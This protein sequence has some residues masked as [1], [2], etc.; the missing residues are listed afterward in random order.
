MRFHLTTDPGLESLAAEEA[1]ELAPGAAI[2]PRPDGRRGRVR[3]DLP[4]RTGAGPLLAMRTIHHVI[5]LRAE[6]E[7]DSLDDVRRVASAVEIP[8]VAGATTF[9]VTT[10]RHGAH[11]FHG[12]EVQQAA[13]G[14]L[15]RRYGTRVDLE[16]PALVVRC[17][18]DGGHLALGIERTPVSLARRLLRPHALRSAL[19]P[20]IAA[21]ML[22]LAGAQR[23]AGRLVDPLCGSGTIP[24]EARAVNPRL[25]VTGSD[26]DEPTVAVAR[27]TARAN[28]LEIDFRVADARDLG[29]IEP[30]AYDWIVTDPPY[31]LRQAR[32]TSLTRLYARLLGS[33]EAALAPG[34]RVALV[35]VKHRVVRAALERTGLAIADERVLVTG[36]VE[37]HV[38]VLERR[39][40][41]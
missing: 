11:P 36:G 19:K 40:T 21:G 17:D 39:G 32:R 22:R 12:F 14:A 28:G 13:G 24:I 20:T 4:D 35:A 34:G 38:F 26:W 10:E 23:G 5:E 31:G 7:V 25:D 2:A 30:G 1:A 27:E 3:V 29:A 9:R 41:I 15:V 8:E 37:P 33:F 16:R 18:L 6:A